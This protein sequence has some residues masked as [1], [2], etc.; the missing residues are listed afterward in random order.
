MDVKSGDDVENEILNYAKGAQASLLVLGVTGM[1]PI[2]ELFLGSTTKMLIS[3]SKIPVIVVPD[4]SK[5]EKFDRL[6]YATTLDYDDIFAIKKISNLFDS[7]ITK[8]EVI[9]VSENEGK[10]PVSKIEAFRKN[11]KSQVSSSNI[12]LKIIYNSDVFRTLKNYLKDQE[13]NILGMLEHEKQV[14][15]KNLFHRDL[16]K[17]M[18]NSINIPLISINQESV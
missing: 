12:E 11:L 9:H 8:I 15:W 4:G 13:V 6:V 3:K 17:R 5:E 1:S 18:E 10:T 16:V 14:L 7:I 2:K